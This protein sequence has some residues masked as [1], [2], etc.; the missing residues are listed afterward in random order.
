MNKQA[1]PYAIRF[2]MLVT[3]VIICALI[4]GCA[5]KR[6]DEN[7]CPMDN[8]I[9][10]QT[11]LLLDTSDPLT[12]K[13]R[14]ELRRLI[15]E[16][17]RESNNAA[18]SSPFYV[19]PG[20]ALFVYELTE[21]MEEVK[22]A[23][24][25]CNPGNNPNEWKWKDDLTKGKAIA[26]Q[27]WQRLE[28]NIGSLFNEIKSNSPR[29]SSPILE[30]L[31]VIVPRHSPSKRNQSSEKTKRPH[32]ILFSDLLQHSSLLSHYKPYPAAKDIKTTDGLRALQTDLTGIDV[33]LFRLERA[34]SGQWQTTEHYYWWTELI[35]EIGGTLNWQESI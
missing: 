9:S 22:H 30:M 29:T 8:P 15:N 21:D 16:I 19:A 33:S 28:A 6:L 7:L 34:D 18:A 10:R 14:A 23:L 1:C 35:M 3:A 17:L 25:I 31:G 26:H 11:I 24:K 4:T 5:Q 12:P 27:Q 20:E 32:L 13:H 2:R